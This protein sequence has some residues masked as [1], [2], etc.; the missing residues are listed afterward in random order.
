MFTGHVAGCVIALGVLAGQACGQHAPGKDDHEWSPRWSAPRSLKLSEFA[1]GLYQPTGQSVLLILGDSINATNSVQGMQ[2][3]YRDRLEIPFNGWVIHADSGNSEI[4]YTNAQ[5]SLA[6]N[7]IRI[8][9]EWFTCGRLGIS[10][11]RTREA[12]WQANVA[13]G[14]TLSDSIL[15]N[16]RMVNMKLGNP[17]ASGAIVDARVI[18]YEGP[19]QLAGFE[20]VGLRGG[21]AVATGNYTRPPT[22]SD[23]IIWIDRALPPG[24]GDPG[25]RLRSDATTAE[26]TAGANS[27]I[28][29]GTRLR[30][31]AAAGVQIEFISHGG[32]RTV[33]HTDTTRFS[34]EALRQY[35]A[36]TDP[37]THILLWIGQNQT[38]AE[39]ANFYT[40]SFALYKHNVEAIISRHDR[41]IRDMGAPE[42]RWLLVSQYKTGYDA[43][44][45]ELMCAGLH[46]ISQE[47]QRVS[48]L[49]LYRI[50]GGEGFNVARYLSDGVHPNFDG[51][52]YIAALMNDE[53]RSALDCAADF[54]GS[55]FVD[56]E[57][58]DSFMAVFDAG[59]ARADVDGSGF[60]DF[61]DFDYFVGLFEVGC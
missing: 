8:P 49:N 51:V 52:Q 23:S 54:D 18:L 14:G 30:A 4:G 27:V 26:A 1:A 11:V 47:R 13:W 61:E 6:V 36:A 53:F 50:A 39:S 44:H 10:P 21:S 3:G 45:H 33:D 59:N 48:F 41:V 29:L 56:I 60:V 17:F 42:P 34:D 24:S 57:D 32:W 38:V 55:G 16:F 19:S 22:P 35:Y 9:G 28:H 15:L 58:F 7:A 25:I 31:R 12:V 46:A 20:A 40:N 5:G 43:F 2:S 37:P